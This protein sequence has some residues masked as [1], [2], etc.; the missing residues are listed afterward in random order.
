MLRSSKY[1]WACRGSQ[2]VGQAGPSGLQGMQ[3]MLVACRGLLQ[4]CQADDAGLRTV[5]Q[6]HVALHLP[7]TLQW[8]A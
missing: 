2:Q 6:V 8:C 4:A 5:L 1:G 3:F 7:G